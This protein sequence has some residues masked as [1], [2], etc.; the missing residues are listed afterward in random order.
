MN[1]AS[2]CR[3]KIQH[4][5]Q[6]FSPTLISYCLLSIVAFSPQALFAQV[7][8]NNVASEAVPASNS[9]TVNADNVK[10]RTGSSTRYRVLTQLSSGQKV[11]KLSSKGEW[12]QIRYQQA[13]GWM[14]SQFLSPVTPAAP[15]QPQAADERATAST[16]TS[17]ATKTKP[18]AEVEPSTA[19]SQLAA[20]TSPQANIS[21]GKDDSGSS[22][23]DSNSGK[24]YKVSADGVTIRRGPSTR[25]INFAYLNKDHQVELISQSKNWSQINFKAPETNQQSQGWLA[26]QFL[27]KARTEAPAP[28]TQDH[29]D[30]LKPA[31]S[32]TEAKPK[33]LAN[34]E[35]KEK[36][37]ESPSKLA[38]AAV[39]IIDT[40]DSLFH[41]SVAVVV[42]Q[43]PF[44]T[45]TPRQP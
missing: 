29:G 16:P 9:Y 30:K 17:T 13:V 22:K 21:S 19:V 32:H 4:L 14:A 35:K 6:F 10:L 15:Q 33:I 44:E 7:P 39:K 24:T 5:Y 42:N 41:N 1:R 31:V 34:Q 45:Y 26:S 2:N 20:Q 37:T 28:A 3:L 12:S 23:N 27:K 11:S 40:K 8:G 38:A 43:G 18:T 25:Y 36:I